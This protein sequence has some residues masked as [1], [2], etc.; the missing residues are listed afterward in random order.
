MSRR[1]VI[2]TEKDVDA[3]VCTIVHAPTL[4][5]TASSDPVSRQ[6]SASPQSPTTG[7]P[8][9][10]PHMNSDTHLR[11]SHRGTYHQSSDSLIQSVAFLV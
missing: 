8:P 10:A 1:A 5:R 6:P 4:P 11:T 7:A 2:G 3:Q 9:L